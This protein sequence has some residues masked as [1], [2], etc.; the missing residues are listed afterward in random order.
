MVSGRLIVVGGALALT[1]ILLAGSPALAQINPS[2][3]APTNAAA[4]RDHW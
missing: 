3:D 1:V 2:T 4:R